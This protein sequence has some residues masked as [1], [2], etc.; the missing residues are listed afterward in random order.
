MTFLPLGL[1]AENKKQINIAISHRAKMVFEFITLFES[2]AS[3]DV[4]YSDGTKDPVTTRYDFA[5][6]DWAHL[7][8]ERPLIFRLLAKLPFTFLDSQIVDT[9]VTEFH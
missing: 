3:H 5:D 6:G 8:D 4:P 2:R 7:V 1:A 9:R